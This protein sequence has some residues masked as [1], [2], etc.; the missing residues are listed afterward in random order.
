MPGTLREERAT[1]PFMRA[2]E[3]EVQRAM[4]LDGADAVS[5]MAAL[6]EAKNAF[7]G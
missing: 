5:V 3:P 4:Q 7:R 1:N 6:R 2:R